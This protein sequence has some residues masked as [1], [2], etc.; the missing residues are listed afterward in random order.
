M[1]ARGTAS[2]P[3]FIRGVDKPVFTAPAVDSER[4]LRFAGAYYVHM[5]RNVGISA[6]A[7]GIAALTWLL[8]RVKAPFEIR[9][10]L[11]LTVIFGVVVTNSV[12]AVTS[13]PVS[14]AVLVMDLGNGLWLHGPT[15]ATY[16]VDTATN[17]TDP[18][19]WSLR[20]TFPLTNG[21]LRLDG[22]PW[23]NGSRRFYRPAPSP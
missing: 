9:F 13:A 14:L 6:F 19:N 16:R 4:E 12:G 10:S 20:G 17:L 2:A 22:P 23:T 11:L 1:S 15:G 5:Y 3:V 8:G 21:V 7:A 18:G